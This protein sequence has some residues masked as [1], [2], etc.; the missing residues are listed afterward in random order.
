M[1]SHGRHHQPGPHVSCVRCRRR[2]TCQRARGR[3]RT[4]L[5]GR[6]ARRRSGFRA[7]VLGRLGARRRADVVGADRGRRHPAGGRVR[8]GGYAGRPHRLPGGRYRRRG[9]PRGRRI[10]AAATGRRGRLRS[11]AGSRPGPRRVGRRP[12]VSGR[13]P[14]RGATAGTGYRDRPRHR[15][16][17]RQ[18]VLRCG[19]R[20][21]H[22][23]AARHPRSDDSA[24]RVLFDPRRRPLPPYLAAAGGA[25]PGVAGVVAGRIAPRSR[26]SRC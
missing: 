6:T 1:R 17:G 22:R 14:R 4:A 19:R 15:D 21:P 18:H 8:R 10:P 3:G 25:A 9:G 11:G 2:R 23:M 5:A 7:G 26:T 16:S 24:Q 20:C 12:C 13:R